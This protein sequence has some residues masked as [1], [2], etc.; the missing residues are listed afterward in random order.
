MVLVGVWKDVY[1]EFEEFVCVVRV[2]ECGCGWVCM[3]IVV[4]VG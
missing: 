1:Y 4:V 3:C 2:G